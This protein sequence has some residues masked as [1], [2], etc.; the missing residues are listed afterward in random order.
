MHRP[1]EWVME[2]RWA[3]SQ[4]LLW[5]QSWWWS[6]FQGST[7]KGSSSWRMKVESR[8]LLRSME[9]G[10][11]LKWETEAHSSATRFR[12][13]QTGWVLLCGHLAWREESP[14]IMFN[15]SSAMNDS[16]GVLCYVKALEF[17]MPIYISFLG[18]CGGLQISTAAE[19]SVNY[20]GVEEHHKT[21]VVSLKPHGMR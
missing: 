17:W 13:L 6:F 18:K 11:W 3:S 4:L 19:A 5:R 10:I 20:S 7:R 15:L 9:S 21:I 16:T 12:Q 1:I 14:A 8:L 2:S